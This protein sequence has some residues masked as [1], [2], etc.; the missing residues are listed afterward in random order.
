M[1]YRK[2]K[3]NRQ[4]SRKGARDHNSQR[5]YSK[6]VAI[7]KKDLARNPDS[8]E[9]RNRLAV[10]YILRE[11]YK[12]ALFHLEKIC[13]LDPEDTS[14]LV[15]LSYVYVELGRYEEGKALATAVLE[16]APDQNPGGCHYILGRASIGLDAYD[17][18]LHHFQAARDIGIE[19]IDF[20][21]FLGQ[22]YTLLNDFDAALKHLHAA[23]A[24]NPEKAILHTS[25]ALLYLKQGKID[26]AEPYLTDA[27]LLDPHARET[28][29][30]FEIFEADRE[31]KEQKDTA[32]EVLPS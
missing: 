2:G 23:L 31:A 9:T 7:L 30:V 21:F 1:K 14:V 20:D 24:L 18:A 26:E 12:E 16:R 19:G 27:L 4:T 13:A 3:K 32:E 6:A 17:E 29:L 10:A 11:E 5:P 25:L 15:N 22:T 28:Q 8:L